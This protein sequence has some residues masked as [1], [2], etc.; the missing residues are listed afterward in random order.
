MSTLLSPNQLPSKMAKLTNERTIRMLTDLMQVPGN[1]EYSTS[2]V[3]ESA[4]RLL[5][6]FDQTFV[7][8]VRVQHLVGRLITWEYSYVFIVQVFTER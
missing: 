4:R 6:Q 7:R 3:P 5:R 2:P 1:G 8:T